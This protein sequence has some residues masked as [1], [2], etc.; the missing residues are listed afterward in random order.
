[1]SEFATQRAVAIVADLLSQSISR[2]CDRLE[3]NC[4]GDPTYHLSVIITLSFRKARAKTSLN[5]Q[6]A[7][8]KEGSERLVMIAPS[9]FLGNPSTETLPIKWHSTCQ[10]RSG[11]STYNYF[12]RILRTRLY[13][14][15]RDESLIHKKNHVILNKITEPLA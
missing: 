7:I 12:N 2:A 14:N 8:S 1:M 15:A 9:F 13:K 6:A 11:F 4:S 3:N 5:T 10:T